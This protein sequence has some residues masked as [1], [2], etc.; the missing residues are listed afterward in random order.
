MKRSILI[1]AGIISLFMVSC[2]KDDATSGSGGGGKVT[3]EN[4]TTNAKN[5]VVD[6]INSDG[7]KSIEA[8]STLMSHDNVLNMRT[9]TGKKKFEQ[10]LKHKVSRFKSIFIPI[11][12]LSNGARTA[13]DSD[14]FVFADHIG[15]YTWN[16]TTKSW[17]VSQTGSIIV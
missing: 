9:I 16:S 8:L 12:K 11:S 2:K 4:A 14:R 6:M 10:V 1:L 17:D 13:N 7:A 3:L 5:D 15:T